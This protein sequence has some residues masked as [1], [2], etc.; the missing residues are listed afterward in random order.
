MSNLYKKIDDLCYEKGINIT[1]MCSQAGVSR[2]S[3]TDLKAGRSK[4]LTN[5][6][7]IKIAGYFNVS[8]DYLNGLSNTKE[9]IQKEKPTVKEIKYAIFNT[10]ENIT[11]EMLEEVKQFA[12]L[13]KLREENKRRD[14]IKQ[15]KNDDEIDVFIA[16][17]S[18]GNTEIP[19]REKMSKSEWERLKSLPETDDDF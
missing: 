6:A 7:L 15:S 19:H 4:T 13:V 17:H 2:G 10:S 16:A 9:P 14:K 18:E 12:E 1:Q 3:L 5:S 8:T 11:D